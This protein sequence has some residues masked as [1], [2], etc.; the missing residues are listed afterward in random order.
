MGG[1]SKKS[2]VDPV[3]ETKFDTQGYMTPGGYQQFQNMGYQPTPQTFTQAGKPSWMQG[4][5]AMPEWGMRADDPTQQVTPDMLDPRTAMFA[6]RDAYNNIGADRAAMAQQQAL[7]QQMMAQNPYGIQGDMNGQWTPNAIQ[8]GMPSG[9]Q[10]AQLPQ[11]PQQG[12]AAAPQQPGAGSVDAA[13]ARYAGRSSALQAPG[14]QGPAQVPVQGGKGQGS[15]SQQMAPGLRNVAQQMSG[16][17]QNTSDAGQPQQFVMPT[18]APA[19]SFW[20]SGYNV[21]A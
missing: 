6:Q 10:P 16:M 9:L 2:K 17:M 19:P 4:Y 18:S 5:F 21:G 11:M 8:G 13:L 14:G 12:Y 7:A 3:R 15:I 20:A 1:G